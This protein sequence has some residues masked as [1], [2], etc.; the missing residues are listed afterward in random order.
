MGDLR[1]LRT[2]TLLQKALLELL[3]KQSF[4]SIKVND[5]CNVAIDRKSVV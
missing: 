2:Y 3:S 5:I 4:D 1:T